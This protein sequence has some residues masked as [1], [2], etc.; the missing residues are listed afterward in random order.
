MLGKRTRVLHRRFYII[1]PT[2]PL[3]LNEAVTFARY[4]IVSLHVSGGGG[5]PPE[6]KSTYVRMTAELPLTFPLRSYCL[7]LYG[8]Y[9]WS[10]NS[11]SINVIEIALNK[12]LRKIWHL[13][14]RSHTGIVHYVSQIPTVSNIGLLA[15]FQ[16]FCYHHL[17]LLDLY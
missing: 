11:S 3:T 9:L 7:S 6:P 5:C 15:F 17:L 4:A 14:P 8:C 16:L 12:I 2:C 10:L 1:V 13:H